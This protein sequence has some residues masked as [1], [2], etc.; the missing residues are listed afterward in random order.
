MVSYSCQI[1]SYQNSVKQLIYVPIVLSASFTPQYFSTPSINA[2][3]AGSFE[4]YQVGSWLH[5][6]SG[7]YFAIGNLFYGL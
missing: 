3:P 1:Q 5:S 4:S 2:R 7:R 6:L